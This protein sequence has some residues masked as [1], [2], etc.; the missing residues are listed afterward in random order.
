M[1]MALRWTLWRVDSCAPRH[2]EQRETWLEK[3][4]LYEFDTETVNTIEL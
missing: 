3:E 4:L 2:K 1:L